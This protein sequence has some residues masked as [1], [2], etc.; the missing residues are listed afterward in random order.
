M[1]VPS[2][3]VQLA[4]PLSSWLPRVAGCAEQLRGL[5]VGL[6]CRRLQHAELPAQAARLPMPRW[7]VPGEGPS[8]WTSR[9]SQPPF[10]SQRSCL[11]DF[12]RQV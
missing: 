10:W 11:A 9:C 8:R 6:V 7:A 3:E 2:E 12:S 4:T 1:P 5:A